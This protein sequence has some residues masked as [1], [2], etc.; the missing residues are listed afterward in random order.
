MITKGGNLQG[1]ETG[2]ERQSPTS[3]GA[4]RG[5]LLQAHPKADRGS[6][7]E[8]AKRDLQWWETGEEK[9]SPTNHGARR[10]NLLRAHPKAANCRLTRT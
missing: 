9:Q 7:H 8:E 3:Q 6:Q 5:N 2:E 4:R 10:G 1:W